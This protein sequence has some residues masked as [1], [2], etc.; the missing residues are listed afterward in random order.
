MIF[1]YNKQQVGDVLLVILTNTNDEKVQVER[2]GKIARV[3]NPET[4]EVRAWN[5]FDISKLFPISGRGQVFL[6]DDEIAVLNAEMEKEGFAERLEND[7]DPKLVVAQIREI[8]DHPDSDHLHICQV[9]IQ[10]G[11]VVQIVCGAPNASL[12]LKTV[13]ALPGAMM[14]D[15]S[16]IFPGSL[17]GV[18]SFGMLCSPR[19][20]ALPNAPQ[21]RGIIELDAE[22]E[23]GQAFDPK[24][25]WK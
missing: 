18:E 5:I 22:I 15:G 12:G 14:P 23:V 25:H 1:S 2:C 7:Q 17:R 24:R 20:L 8:Q 21:K 11:Q 4:N 19:E 6:T 10:D 16:L 9:E 3:F 13:A